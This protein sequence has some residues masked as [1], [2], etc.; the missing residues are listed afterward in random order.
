MELREIFKLV[1]ELT[2]KY[3]NLNY[4]DIN[5]LRILSSRLSSE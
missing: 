4:N 2:S 3:P 1:N 5:E